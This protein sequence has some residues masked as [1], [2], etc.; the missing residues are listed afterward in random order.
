M[1]NYDSWVRKFFSVHVSIFSLDNPS[2]KNMT[3]YKYNKLL[4]GEGSK[5]LLIS[6]FIG[7]DTMIT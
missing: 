2:N 6:N 4:M 5:R 7:V 3:Y 1:K